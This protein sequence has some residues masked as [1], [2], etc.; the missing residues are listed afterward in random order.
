MA[1]ADE[2][3]NEHSNLLQ[4]AAAAADGTAALE[5]ES[6][7]DVI[8]NRLLDRMHAF[9]FNKA[10]VYTPLDMLYDLRPLF[11]EDVFD[12]LERAFKRGTN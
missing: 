12:A 6:V 8:A 2:Y 1:A 7:Q 9:S 5:H 11:K 3:A 4:P 10:H